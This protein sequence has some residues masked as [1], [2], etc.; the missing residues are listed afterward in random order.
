MSCIIFKEKLMV[1]FE[2]KGQKPLLHSHQY[3]VPT[4]PFTSDNHTANN[5]ELVSHSTLNMYT[6]KDPYVGRDNVR[7][8]NS[9]KKGARF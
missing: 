8:V 6:Y 2:F 1:S 3:W 5:T 7:Y 9:L 4:S